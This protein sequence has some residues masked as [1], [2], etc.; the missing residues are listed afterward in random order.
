MSVMGLILLLSLI[1]IYH[2]D[3]I[4]YISMN[5][6]N[7]NDQDE[8]IHFEKHDDFSDYGLYYQSSSNEETFF[9]ARVENHTLDKESVS[10][11][12]LDVYKRQDMGISWSTGI[13]RS[14]GQ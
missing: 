14:W 13:N 10:Y 2:Q 5:L 4:E 8:D 12:H 7:L 9:F 11:T 1:H 3:E 6:K